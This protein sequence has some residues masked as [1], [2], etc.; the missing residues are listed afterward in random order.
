M[1]NNI[2][3]IKYYSLLRIIYLFYKYEILGNSSLYVLIVPESGDISVELLRN[4]TLSPSS[5]GTYSVGP[6][7]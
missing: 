6:N 1:K 2:S 3:N 4:W 7:R 5:G